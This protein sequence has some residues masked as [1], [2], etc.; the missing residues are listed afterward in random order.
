MDATITIRLNVMGPETLAYVTQVISN[1]VSE[2][3][4]DADVY[5]K[6]EGE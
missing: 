6:I 3:D 4:L 5:N 1:T 2:W